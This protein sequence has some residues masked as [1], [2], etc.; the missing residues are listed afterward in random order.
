LA[1]EGP[2]GYALDGEDCARDFAVEERPAGTKGD[3]NDQ[4]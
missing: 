3:E 1:A 4:A 2:V